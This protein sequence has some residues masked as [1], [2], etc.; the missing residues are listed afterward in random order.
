MIPTIR[1]PVHS[2]VDLITNSSSEIYVSATSGTIEALKSVINTLLKSQGIE[3]KADELFNIK[4]VYAVKEYEKT[5][6]DWKEFDTEDERSKW[7]KEN[8][9]EEYDEYT[10]L[11]ENLVI[12]PKDK[13][14]KDLRKVADALHNLVYSTNAFEGQ[15]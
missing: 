8:E 11:V 4:L 6:G 2:F 9:L 12:E 1:I 10:T 3:K 7:M 13:K 5:N 15:Q 14:N